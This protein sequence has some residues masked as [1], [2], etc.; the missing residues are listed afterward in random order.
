MFELLPHDIRKIAQKRYISRLISLYAFGLFGLFLIGAM[1]TFPSYMLVSSK[2]AAALSEKK[3]AEERTK[4]EKSDSVG[5]LISSAK[6]KIEAVKA[7]SNLTQA[8]PAVK[9]V[10]SKIGSGISL[11]NLSFSRTTTG[12]S[13]TKVL[14]SGIAGT[15]ENLIAF[16]DSLKSEKRFIKVNV[17]VSSFAK[18]KNADFSISIEG[19]F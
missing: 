18:N 8:Y 11:T 6:V 7:V 2:E 19:K 5:L 17:P 15:R 1:L 10:L 13:T 12:D 3:V 16:S 9:L 14:I 4:V